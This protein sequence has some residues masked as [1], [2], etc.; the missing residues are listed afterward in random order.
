[1]VAISAHKVSNFLYQ[2]DDNFSVWLIEVSSNK[3]VYFNVFHTSTFK[4]SS[5]ELGSRGL[6]RLPRRILLSVHM[7]SIIPVDLDENQ[8]TQ[9]K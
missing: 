2:I 3:K 7:E 4:A 1:M 6:A 9:P 8:E 5:Y